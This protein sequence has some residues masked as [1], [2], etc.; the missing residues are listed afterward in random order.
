MGETSGITKSLNKKRHVPLN[1]RIKARQRHCGACASSWCLYSDLLC[2]TAKR[3]CHRTYEATTESE[4]G[5]SGHF[6][7]VKR[8]QSGLVSARGIPEAGQA[9]TEG[10]ETENDIYVSADVQLSEIKEYGTLND[11]NIS[12]DVHQVEGEEY[13]TENDMYMSADGHQ[14]GIGVC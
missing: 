6:C 4:R 11:L 1:Q 8:D 2:E 12:A 3:C 5:M 14:S 7:H 10:V 13:E 9:E